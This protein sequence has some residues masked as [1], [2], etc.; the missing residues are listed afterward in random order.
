[1]LIPFRPI[2]YVGALLIATH[3]GVPGGATAEYSSDMTAAQPPATP[4]AQEEL[5][6]WRPDSAIGLPGDLDPA[7]APVKQPELS[8]GS[9][10]LSD[11]GFP[12]TP[13]KYVSAPAPVA[14]TEPS[15]PP[16]VAAAKSIVPKYEVEENSHVR[17]FLD[18]FQ[19]GY[20]R[21]VVERWLP[22]RPLPADD[23]GRVPAEGAA[24]GAGVHRDDR[25]RVRP[26]GGV[27][28]GGQGSLAV[29]GVRRPAATASGSTSGSTSAST[30]RSPRWLRPVT[31]SIFTRCL[32]PGTSPRRPTTRGSG[33]SRGD[34]GHGH[35][36]LLGASRGR[37]PQG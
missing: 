30:P 18:Q 12:R 16:V 6:N 15:A 26:L 20:R 10:S 25:E 29:H 31:A 5:G 19:T 32:A 22:R 27:A 4:G 7:S 17:R 8:D 14:P 35:Q 13:M 9:A 24:R 23:P 37:W 28:R 34:S 1:M 3:L 2:L 36:R 33:R 21:A 11:P